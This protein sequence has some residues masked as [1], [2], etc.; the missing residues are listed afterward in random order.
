MKLNT[1]TVVGK[2]YFFNAKKLRFYMNIKKTVDKMLRC[3]CNGKIMP[4]CESEV[5]QNDEFLSKLEKKL[6][7]L[8]EKY[9][10]GE[11]LFMEKNPLNDNSSNAFCIRA[12]KTW[13]NQQI[14][15]VW[16]PI[17]D[18]SREF[19]NAEGVETLAEI[20]SVIVSDRY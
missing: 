3:D 11:V 1:I 7:T 12:P 15:D 2:K 14:F 17:S 8:S 5:V 19:A 10:L 16:G 18:E 4:S 13:T 20:C 6:I 9:G